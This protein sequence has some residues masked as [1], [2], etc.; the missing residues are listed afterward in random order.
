M[1]KF[2]LDLRSLFAVYWLKVFFARKYCSIYDCMIFIWLQF[3]S[4]SQIVNNIP[5]QNSQNSKP[6]RELIENGDFHGRPIRKYSDGSIK[7]VTSAGWKKFQSFDE[8]CEYHWK[9]HYK[10]NPDNKKRKIGW[11]KRIFNPA[12][13]KSN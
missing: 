12:L 7:A 10:K 8:F 2:S 13:N 3:N 11:L 6:A 9:N 4:E 1:N 5:P